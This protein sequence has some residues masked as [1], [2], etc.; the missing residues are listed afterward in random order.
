M[1]RVGAE[2]AGGKRGGGGGGGGVRREE[3]TSGYI[4][5]AHLASCNHGR[6]TGWYAGSC[7]G[8]SSRGE[9]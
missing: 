6:S 7:V 4:V 9:R 3:S 2:G 1:R 8:V 5:L